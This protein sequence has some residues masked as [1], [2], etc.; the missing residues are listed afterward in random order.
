M[1]AGLSGRNRSAQFDAASQWISN[2]QH[3]AGAAQ[4]AKLLLRK[5][6]A[7]VRF[8][9]NVLRRRANLRFDVQN[10]LTQPLGRTAVRALF[11]F[12]HFGRAHGF[13]Q[14]DDAADLRAAR[15]EVAQHDVLRPAQRGDQF[16]LH[17]H[18]VRRVE[19]FQRGER[20]GNAK[21]KA[22]VRFKHR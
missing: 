8:V 5:A 16:I 10:V 17:A 20:S 14:I 15:I 21:F 4:P 12:A 2:L 7:A 22:Q 3:Q 1:N 6:I 11:G 9:M 13:D 18:V 19:K